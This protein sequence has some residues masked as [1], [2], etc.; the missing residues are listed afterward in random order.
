M[1]VDRRLGRVRDS[2]R[3]KE[4]NRESFPG[5]LMTV[6][7]LVLVHGEGHQHFQSLDS[8][9]PPCSYNKFFFFCLSVFALTCNEEILL[10]HND[11]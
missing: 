11:L 10:R 1:G 9:T 2:D 6:Q 8:K 3:D 7:L 5:F 4:S